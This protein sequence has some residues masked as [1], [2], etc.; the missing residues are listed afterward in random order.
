MSLIDKTS[1]LI[2]SQLPSFISEDVN[3][4]NFVAFLQA[5]YEWM[6]QGGIVMSV[7]VITG[8][9]GYGSD[10]SVTI[11]G[12]GTGASAYAV[13]NTHGTVQQIIMSS[14]GSGYTTANV[15]I[16]GANQVPASASAVIQNGN[17]YDSKNLLN[18]MDVDNTTDAFI[19]Y[20]INEF[21]P[22]FP[23]DALISK[24]KAIKVARQIYKSKGT[25]ASYELLFRMLYNSSFDYY[26]T[27]DLVL[28]ASSGQWYVPKSVQLLATDERFLSITNYR[29]F[30]ETSKS[31]ATIENSLLVNGKIEVF[32]SNIERLFQSGEEVRVV[33][34]NNRDVIING[35]NLRAKIIGQISTITINPQYKG[36][37]YVSGDPV[38]LYGGLN[39][40]VLNPVGASAVV[41][42]VVSGTIQS[43]SL[44]SGGQ[45]YNLTQ[46]I[47]PT[48]DIGFNTTQSSGYILPTA[49]VV[50]VDSSNAFTV[51]GLSIDNLGLKTSNTN[52][53]GNI[54]SLSANNFF[55]QNGTWV[56][57]T[58]T[59]TAQTYIVGEIVYQ[60]N[61]LS[62]TFEGTVSSYNANNGVIKI[63]SVGPSNTSLPNIGQAITGN[64]SHISFTANT[65]WT[66]N[67]NSQI[68]EVLSTVSYTGYP[69]SQVYLITGGSNL[70]TIPSVATESFYST[71]NTASPALISS[72]GI[73]GP[74]QISYGGQNYRVNDKIVF[75]GGSGFGANAYVS[76]VSNTG[77]ITG[78]T[79]RS[80]NGIPSGGLNY[81]L[82]TLPAVTVTSNTATA[83]AI[84]YA[85]SIIGQGAIFDLISSQIGQIQTIDVTNYG[86]DYIAAPSVSLKIQDI[87]VSGISTA[88][89]PKQ[90]DVIYQGTSNTQTSYTATIYSVTQLGPT[91]PNP[92]NT[93]Y[94]LRVFNYSSNPN[95]SLPLVDSS[96]GNQYTMTGPYD[97]TWPAAGYINYGDG[98]AR[99]T[100]AFLNGLT[101][102]K[103]QYLSSSGQLS[104]F[105]V[106]QSEN[107]NSFT[108]QIT[109]QKEIAK[110]RSVLLNLLHP[111]GTKLL[112]RYSITQNN[113]AGFVPSTAA[114]KAN[115]LLHYTGTAAAN[116]TMFANTSTV[117]QNVLQFNNLPQGTNIAEF[118]FANS[119]IR[120]APVNGPNVVSTISSIDSANNL[121]VLN[122]KTI[123]TFPNTFFVSY[124]ANTNIV[125]VDA[126]TELYTF[127]DD[128]GYNITIDNLPQFEQSPFLPLD[129]ML[130]AGD[131]IDLG[132]NNYMQV[133]AIDYPNNIIALTGTT[134]SN[135][136][137][138]SI[139]VISGGNSY[140]ANT[141]IYITGN[142]TGATA[143][144]VIQNGHITSV[145]ITNGGYGYTFAFAAAN[146]S[147]GTGA[148]IGNV[149]LSEIVSTVPMTIV[150]NFYAGGSSS[151]A[152]EIRIYGQSGLQ[153]FPEITDELGDPLLSEDGSFILLG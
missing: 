151:T 120:I 140:D 138:S 117:Y 53:S 93:I 9:L 40:E 116:V 147:F 50:G 63:Q 31:F 18:Y 152:D 113:V 131:Y 82:T 19:D 67:L 62:P 126:P 112:G 86:Q 100:A 47:Y 109:T 14:Y 1:I 102:G 68:G 119:T 11:D 43:I 60:G 54:I 143:V 104:S 115:T 17:T 137:I 23:A 107:Y 29:L 92:L 145:Q 42:S 25:P 103:G 114:S 89:L 51:T 128:Y 6:E 80:M 20:F 69:I 75:T 77:A 32:L 99:A 83:N 150:R 141:T 146:S 74:I 70:T 87:A 136:T 95:L 12:D 130:F 105:D 73:L 125:V 121:V 13:L 49:Q 88:T 5:Y 101:I 94:N 39:Q 28:K 41:G 98:T 122:D 110:Y 21:M 135:L 64:T 59:N 118:I 37:N 35:T 79:Y 78:I 61:V 127:N 34:N 97:S 153:Y 33:D 65:Y 27:G 134:S 85:S 36:L 15:T 123:L 133:A 55:F 48:T 72:L 76:N 16:N 139:P 84:L 132:S 81:S 57:V 7:N 91:T 2:P 30:G 108:Y 56:Q 90:F 24:D 148:V 8:G 26:N 71:E 96:T 45:G 22:Y 58:T 111:I 66:S 38:V 142:G 106:I 144:P 124:Q 10:I 44:L 4:E 149:A 129:V 3:N 52:P 46:A